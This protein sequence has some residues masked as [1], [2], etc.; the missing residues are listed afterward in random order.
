MTRR[1]IGI[2]LALLLVIVGG[3][4]ALVIHARRTTTDSGTEPPVVPTD[5]GHA[6]LPFCIFHQID[7]VDGN[8]KGIILN[9]VPEKQESGEVIY[10][11]NRQAP[12]PDWSF[13]GTF[14][15]VTP[16]F[17]PV[18]VG[19]RLFCSQTS[20]LGGIVSLTDVSTPYGMFHFQPDCVYFMTYNQSTIHTVP[21]YLHKRGS[22]VF[23]SFD[24]TPPG[25]GW[26]STAISPI[27]VLTAGVVDPD[28]PDD[29]KFHCVNGKCSPWDKGEL[30]H[31]NRLEEKTPYKLNE[32][33]VLC[34]EPV[35]TD[36]DSG[37]PSSILQSVVRMSHQKPLISTFFKTLS[38]VVVGLVIGGF[39][40]LLAL[41]LHLLLKNKNERRK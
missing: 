28:H 41:L 32:C 2:G 6:I 33:V 19:M 18:P 11:C 7:L 22:N 36:E 35:L 37:S 24:A 27:Y 16:M 15:A 17:R 26:D 29:T 14:Y 10:R 13:A 23:P 39:V 21:L 1:S 40:L 4:V 34:N 25:K 30:L 31:Y 38:P 8:H 12:G 5:A 20:E 3:V 9:P